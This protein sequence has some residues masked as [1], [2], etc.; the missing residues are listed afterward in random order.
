[1]S[2]FVAKFFFFSQIHIMQLIAVKC[3]VLDGEGHIVIT[4]HCLSPGEEASV[5]VHPSDCMCV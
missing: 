4:P 3:H 5:F 1:M 2:N